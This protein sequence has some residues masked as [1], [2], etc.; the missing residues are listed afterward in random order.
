M[1][2]PEYGRDVCGAHCLPVF[3]VACEYWE[4]QAPG[5]FSPRRHLCAE[6]GT[7]GAV[8]VMGRLHN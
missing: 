6:L 5:P 3:I 2:R 7:Q 8:N 4:I 1:N